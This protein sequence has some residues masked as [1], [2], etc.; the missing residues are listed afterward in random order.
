MSCRLPW[1]QP[2]PVAH[3][4]ASS[5]LLLPVCACAHAPGVGAVA[6]RTV[7]VEGAVLDWSAC[8]DACASPGVTAPI[9]SNRV[10]VHVCLVGPGRG[11]GSRRQLNSLTRSAVCGWT[12][13]PSGPAGIDASGRACLVST[14]CAQ[15][16]QAQSS[17]MVAHLV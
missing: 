15:E 8:P 2:G 11:L 6:V 12:E 3:C 14:T 7:S 1:E 9:V 13:P 10:I 17:C 5:I 4:S 16:L